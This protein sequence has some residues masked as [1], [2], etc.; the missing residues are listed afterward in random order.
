VD[1]TL[2]S[3]PVELNLAVVS[4]EAKPRRFEVGESVPAGAVCVS[5]AVECI[6]VR[7]ARDST[8]E[9]LAEL[10]STL[11]SR[12]SKVQ[13][14]ADAFA[15]ALVP[16]V[17]LLA[18]G[19]LGFWVSRGQLERGVLA[20]LAVVLAA[21][22]CTYS[23][24]T[25]LVLWLALRK[26][27]RHG[28]L[29]RSPEALEALSH[30]SAIAFD[31]T[32]TVTSQNLSVASVALAPGRSHGEVGAYVA[33]LEEG[34]PHPVGRALLAWALEQK[35]APAALLGRRFDPGL[36]V[37]AQDA[38][39]VEL[40]LGSPR[41]LGRDQANPDT[42]VTLVRGDQTL[43]SFV[44]DEPLR[45]EAA[46]AIG[47]LAGLGI[48]STLLTGDGEESA[49]RVADSLGVACRANLSPEE[50][51]E[52]LET[53]GHDAAMVGDGVND[54]PALA[55]A[56]LGFAMGHGSGL[57]RGLAQATLLTPDLRL[58]PW[59]VA[60]A[61]RTMAL[62]RRNLFGSTIYNLVFLGLAAAGFLRPVVA[63][64]AML[65]SSLLVLF[66]ALRMDALPGPAFEERGA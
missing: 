33:A 65:A 21:C 37:R 44:I 49:R 42:R 60:L 18:L 13:R 41:L 25:P 8:V 27:L 22:P 64:L 16:L 31:K 47:E 34:S 61:R 50:K 17:F 7:S 1:A 24:T 43:A 38:G 12:P 15:T 30:V 51:V 52:A 40:L 11:R 45:P 28:V 4:G 63:G 59:T 46:Q 29:V 2:A 39:G 35:A 9:R 20:S 10:A 54:A 57:S 26:A 3:G 55:R 23:V 48:R 5:G 58:V 6:A 32:G 14:W 53:L 36:G 66:S 56:R 62:A 19:C